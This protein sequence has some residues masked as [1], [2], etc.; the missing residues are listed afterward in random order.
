[1]R[2]PQPKGTRKCQNRAESMAK[3]A[4]LKVK[5]VQSIEAVTNPF[6]NQNGGI[7]SLY[8][9]YMIQPYYYQNLNGEIATSIIVS[10]NLDDN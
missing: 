4:G 10:L 1:V 6:G 7:T 8:V 5:G 3:I 9:V 2:Y